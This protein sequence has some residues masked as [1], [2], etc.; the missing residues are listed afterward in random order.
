MKAKKGKVNTM[1][2]GSKYVTMAMD[3]ENGLYNNAIW[4]LRDDL[5]EELQ[6][7]IANMCD[8]DFVDL[9]NEYIDDECR[10]ENISSV[11]D[12]DSDF[13]RMYP[14]E[15]F[16]TFSDIDFSDSWYLSDCSAS[17]DNPQDLVDIDNLVEY[18]MDNDGQA[19][20]TTWEIDD[21][22]E[23]YERVKNEIQEIQREDEKREKV[24]NKLQEMVLFLTEKASVEML[25]AATVALWNING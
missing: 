11:S 24:A 17:A 2:D 6:D 22:F 15:V 25:E 8:T 9:W 14:S 16:E 1:R 20:N 19:L 13:G 12:I 5:R 4:V 23:E 10:D 18:L 7:T 21:L 3:N